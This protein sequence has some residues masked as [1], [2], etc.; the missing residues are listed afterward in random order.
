MQP[1]YSYS[2]AKAQ[3]DGAVATHSAVT[4]PAKTP[5]A[6]P[7]A[8][9][10]HA[11][12]GLSDDS[13]VS[14][15]S[16]H[17]PRLTRSS[18]F[19]SEASLFRE[20]AALAAAP[21]EGTQFSHELS[22]DSRGWHRRHSSGSF[23]GF[24]SPRITSA[25]SGGSSHGAPGHRKLQHTRWAGSGGS[26]SKGRR[27]SDLGQHVQSNA[28]NIAHQ[29]HGSTDSTAAS[30]DTGSAVHAAKGSGDRKIETAEEQQV[31]TAQV[32]HAA[33]YSDM[34]QAYAR[35]QRHERGFDGSQRALPISD[36]SGGT[37]Q[38]T[39]AECSAQPGAAASGNAMR[40]HAA[41]MADHA[42]T[43][44]T[45]SAQTQHAT[46]PAALM[47]AHLHSLQSTSAHLTGYQVGHSHGAHTPAAANGHAGSVA[48]I[49][50]ESAWV[51]RWWR[52]VALMRDDQR[53]HQADSELTQLEASTGENRAQLAE[54]F[55]PKEGPAWLEALRQMLARLRALA[56]ALAEGIADG[57]SQNSGPP[58]QV[59]QQHPLLRAILFNARFGAWRR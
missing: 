2:G 46:D 53:W 33:V 8:A 3:G 9:D 23:P 49:D 58:L 52:C 12:G 35:G 39:W 38:D 36:M 4:T 19:E 16:S 42:H 50:G 54:R 24:A 51:E 20:A 45:H 47:Q 31:Q 34:H 10:A 41:A 21:A 17:A 11:S 13:F 29:R 18:S 22:H 43:V 44:R 26:P 59:P 27:R 56:A 30:Q 5:V 25:E 37:G 55:D 57:Y 15:R 7:P 32:S 6:S 48:A 1:V 40:M 28:S 14:A